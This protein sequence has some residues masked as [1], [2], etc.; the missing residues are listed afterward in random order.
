[1]HKEFKKIL[2][3]NVL[4]IVIPLVINSIAILPFGYPPKQDPYRVM[5]P[6]FGFTGLFILFVAV[7]NFI[8]AIM[9]FFLKEA[10]AKYYLLA[11]GISLLID[12]GICSLP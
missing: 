11:A 4:L 3:S 12:G 8:L 1:M 10:K 6:S 2:I 5:L 7:V 9:F